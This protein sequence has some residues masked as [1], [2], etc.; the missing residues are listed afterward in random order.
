MKILYTTTSPMWLFLLILFISP[1][2]L[3]QDRKNDVIVKR[4]SSKITCKVLVVND[5]TVQYKKFNDPDGPLFNI[6][7]SDIAR[8][9][10]GNGETE[11]YVMPVVAPL[12]DNDA[13]IMYPISPWRSPGFL[14]D[15]SI[16]K[17]EELKSARTFYQT[18]VKSAKAKS[19]VF[20]GVGAAASVLGI[21]LIATQRNEYYEVHPSTGEIAL[22]GGVGFGVIGGLA[23]YRKARN[24]RR[25]VQQVEGELAKRRV[26]GTQWRI[27]PLVNP[28]TR[29]ASVSL[30]FQF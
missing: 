14:D 11:V 29:S 20:I 25:N 26:T 2:T 19:M 18:G 9:V 5:Q 4:D 27:R 3:G 10:Y 15:L 12:Y 22:I 7:K 28:N 8:I 21:I 23:C 13:V 1:P 24:Y 16:W 6:L 17:P 30:A